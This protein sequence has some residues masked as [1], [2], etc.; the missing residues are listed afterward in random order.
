MVRGGDGIKGIRKEEFTRVVVDGV[1]G[2]CGEQ[3]ITG[4]Q[5]KKEALL[6]IVILAPINASF[7]VIS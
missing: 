3:N 2:I 4:C 5:N 1:L 7:S 6:S